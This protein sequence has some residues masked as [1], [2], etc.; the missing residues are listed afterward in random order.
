MAFHKY[1]VLS[2]SILVAAL[3]KLGLLWS[4]S[5]PFNS[6]EAVIGLMARH[7]LQGERPVFFYGQAY[8]GSLDAWLAALSFSL[9]GESVW[10]IRFVQIGLYLAFI[11]TSWLIARRFF[12]DPGIANI[13]AILAAI[14]PL[15]ITTYTSATLGGYGE[16]LLLGNLM[17]LIGYEVGRGRWRESWIA[18]LSLGLIAGLA[19]WTLGLAVVFLTAIFIFVLLGTI[20]KKRLVQYLIGLAGFIVGSLP[21]WIYNLENQGAAFAVLTQGSPAVSTPASRL[22]GMLLLGF[23]ALLGIRAPW[24]PGFSPLLM[25]A[26]LIFLY[27]GILIFLIKGNVARWPNGAKDSGK[28]IFLVLIVF[29]ALFVGTQFGLDATGRYFLPL[30]LPLLLIQAAFIH[31]AWNW[32]RFLGGIALT[33]ILASHLWLT[34]RA[35]GSEEK[36][37]TQFDP[38]T[39]FDNQS[40]QEL[41]EFL[42]RQGELYGYSNYWVSFRLAFLSRE[43]IIYSPEL[44]YKLDFRYTERDQRYPAYGQLVDANPKAAYITTLHPALDQWLRDVFEIQRIEYKEAE[45]GPYRVFYQLS[46][47]IRPERLNL[48]S[49]ESAP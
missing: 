25:I 15:L 27:A 32:N 4:E 21:W 28:L 20:T 48:P 10:A 43:E 49:P 1:G 35:A 26:P 12:A 34:M 7:I 23:P 38:I 11:L 8:M 2:L 18:W 37:T 45:I 39:R 16:I 41:M 17:L 9:F 42:Y 44:P 31:F 6:D 36:I 29:I 47:S 46:E 30:F 14:P 33:V 5:I 40:D 3:L 13:V 19:F 24:E 22:L